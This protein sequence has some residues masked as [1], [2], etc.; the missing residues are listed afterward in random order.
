MATRK[1]SDLRVVF[2]FTDG[3]TDSLPL[4]EV[5][6]QE[7]EQ[8]HKLGRL[9]ALAEARKA[10]VESST[11]GGKRAAATRREAAGT[12][13]EKCIDDARRLIASGTEPR[14]VA[15]K[16]AQRKGAKHITTIRK[17]LRKASVI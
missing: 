7:R 3:S 4:L 9:E 14:N 12:W 6:R 13:Q 16:L 1:P 17:V 15:G 8:M 5:M 11:K 10:R 2:K